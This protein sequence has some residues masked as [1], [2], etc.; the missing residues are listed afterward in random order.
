MQ[1]ASIALP[2][3]VAA[4]SGYYTWLSD[5]SSRSVGSAAILL[6]VSSFLAR[7]LRRRSNNQTASFVNVVIDPQD[8]EGTKEQAEVAALLGAVAL[9][10]L[11]L[12]MLCVGK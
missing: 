1:W 10:M 12:S 8:E 4:A 9:M 11:A 5:F 2:L 6:L 7:F 3:V